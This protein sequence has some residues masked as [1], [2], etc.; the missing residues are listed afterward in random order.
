M[1]SHL[2]GY[3]RFTHAAAATQVR[4]IWAFPIYRIIVC[5]K[6]DLQYWRCRLF[7]KKELLCGYARHN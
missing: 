2:L 6:R 3:Y 5:H 1:R 7:K 4:P